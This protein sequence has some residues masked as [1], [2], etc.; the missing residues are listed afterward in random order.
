MA[1]DDGERRPAGSLRALVYAALPPDASPTDTAC[2]PLHRH[3]LDKAQGDVVALTR[4]KMS[5]SFGDTPH[6]V[7]EVREGDLDPRTDGE[8]VGLL[9]QTEG[10]VLVFG[11]AYA[12]DT[13]RPTGGDG[14]RFNAG[15]PE[16]PVQGEEC[17]E[18]GST[19]AFEVQRAEQ[20]DAQG[21]IT[22]LVE[23]RECG[24]VWDSYVS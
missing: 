1:T 10:G 4:E 5:A 17:Q 6:V 9:E 20:P 8:L 22:R 23:C 11:V 16:K 18:C 14:M 13:P 21:R 24:T 12:V 7:V 3:V 15:G 19:D 2:Q